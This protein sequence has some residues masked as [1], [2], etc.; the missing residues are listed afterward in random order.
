MPDTL[1]SDGTKTAG[2]TNLELLRQLGQ[3]HIAFDRRQGH[4]G[5]EGRPVIASRSLHR[6]APLVR[7]HPVTLV[8]PGYHLAHCP[9]LRSPL[10][11]ITTTHL[12]LVEN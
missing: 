1:P 10:C 4:L 8:K 3:R 5:L 9:N 7:H 6:L 11:I 12:W 2:P